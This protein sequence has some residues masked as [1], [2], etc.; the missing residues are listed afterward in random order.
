MKNRKVRYVEMRK[1]IF[2]SVS[3]LADL[4]YQKRTWLDPDGATSRGEYFDFDQ[5]FHIL[6]DDTNGLAKNPSSTV[7]IYLYD[8]IEADA[9]SILISAIEVLLNRFGPFGTVEQFLSAPEW[10]S[11]VLNAQVVLDAMK[12]NN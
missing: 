4:G 6:F 11:V 8:Q 2:N 7:G 5:I 3:E 1:E 10:S 12:R 9:F